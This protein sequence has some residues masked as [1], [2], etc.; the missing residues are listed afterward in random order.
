M[1]VS[2][3]K[4]IA[5]QTGPESCVAHRKIRDEPLTGEPAGQPLSGESHRQHGENPNWP[6]ALLT[7]KTAAYSRPKVNP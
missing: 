4:G 1:E 6:K 7:A 3:R 2:N 5:N